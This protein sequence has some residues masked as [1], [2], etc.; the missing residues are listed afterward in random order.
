MQKTFLKLMVFEL[1]ERLVRLK[2]LLRTPPY[3]GQDSSVKL[4][5]RLLK[6]VQTLETQ[7]L[8]HQSVLMQTLE[9]T[10]PLKAEQLFQEL[11]PA[12]RALY[13]RVCKLSQFLVHQQ[14]FRVL[15]ETQIFLEA[16]L[17]Y[18]LINHHEQQSVYLIAEGEN[19][20]QLSGNLPEILINALPILQRNNPLGWVGLGAAL[21]QELLSQNT[22]MDGLGNEIYKLEKERL[23][24]TAI[25]NTVSTFLT[26][27][28]QLRLL[29]PSYYFHIV[30]EAALTQNAELLGAIEP[31]LF[32][33][34]N[35]QNFTHKSVVLLHEACE[36][37][38]LI[39]N[40]HPPHPALT[41]ES[42]A[43]LF[44]TT[45]KIL[46]AKNAFQDKHFQ[47]AI[48]L[49]GRMSEGVLI[50]STPLYPLEEVSNNLMNTIGEAGFSIYTPLAMITEYPHNPREMLNAGWLHKIE[51]L[52]VWLYTVLQDNHFEG[53]H[54]LLEEQDQRLQKSIEVSEIHRMLLCTT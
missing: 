44:S 3:D 7:F 31:V 4:V 40:P 43:K 47:R 18:S 13:Q 11:I 14:I 8:S 53:L 37:S 1:L 42:L 45:E 26:H 6:E 17:P 27:A 48:K 22:I 23:S 52:S 33:G 2:A 34:L 46:P 39:L 41:D 20:L 28:I 54:I 38:K 50:S 30:S 15:P 12:L 36:R 21:T 35:H 29:G 16:T 9:D 25:S 51:Q 49:Q 19:P 10:S 24:R 5:N 32:F